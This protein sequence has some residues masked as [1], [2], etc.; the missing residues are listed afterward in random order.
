MNV[1]RVNGQEY[2][3]VTYDL[4]IGMK[5]HSIQALETPPFDKLLIILNNFY[6]ELALFWI[7]GTLLNESG[8]EYM[9]SEADI[10]TEGSMMGFIKIKFHSCCIE[11][12]QLLANVM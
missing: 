2:A 11:I 9:L 5:V 1:T 10:L 8:T 3:V 4:A 6:T 12:H 7:V